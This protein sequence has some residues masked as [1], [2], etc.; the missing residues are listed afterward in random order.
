VIRYVILGIAECCSLL[1]ILTVI[2]GGL[3][4][5]ISCLIIFLMQIAYAIVNINTLLYTNL[6]TTKHSPLVTPENVFTSEQPWNA[7]CQIQAYLIHTSWMVCFNL[8]RHPS[9]YLSYSLPSSIGYS[10]TGSSRGSNT[11][12]SC[13]WPVC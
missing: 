3:Y 8:Y 13:Y 2:V 1:V 7:L 6:F 10:P 4:K 9:I 11:K 12:P 5:Y